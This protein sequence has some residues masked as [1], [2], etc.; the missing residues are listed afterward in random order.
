M[1][2]DQKASGGRS[3]L[4]KSQ[5]RWVLALATLLLMSAIVA[6]SVWIP[7]SR[8]IVQGADISFTPV[9]STTVPVATVPPTTEPPQA[10]D[11]ISSAVPVESEIDPALCVALA[12][13]LIAEGASQGVTVLFGCGNQDAPEFIATVTRPIDVGDDP[14]EGSLLGLLAGPTPGE[15]ASGIDSLFSLDTA[16]ALDFVTL[17][18]GELVVDFNHGIYVNNVSTSTGG[19]FFRAELLANVFQYPEVDTVEFQIDGSCELWAAY[20]ESETC[21]VVTR[22]DWNILQ[23]GWTAAMAEDG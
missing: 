5:K 3:G 15:Q 10:V 9:D 6:G 13:S 12:D 22:A 1:I 21:E 11:S 7:V 17:N 14:V 18:A 8:V 20:F 4:T 16:K 19:V 23:A 2:D